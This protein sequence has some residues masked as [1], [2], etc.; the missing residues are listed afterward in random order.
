MAGNDVYSR[1]E[2]R[3]IF[4]LNEDGRYQK[5]GTDQNWW[6]MTSLLDDHGT[7]EIKVLDWEVA[8]NG[9]ATIT[10]FELGG[11]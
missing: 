1:D 9:K 2:N 6:S 3:T 4:Y 7:R 10:K 8:E 5:V 11:I